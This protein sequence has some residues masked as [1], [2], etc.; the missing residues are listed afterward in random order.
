VKVLS[1]RRVSGRHTQCSPALRA[2]AQ[3]FSLHARV[4]CGAGERKQLDASAARK[5]IAG[6]KS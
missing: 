3:G 1:L 2:D 5:K 4:R 6:K